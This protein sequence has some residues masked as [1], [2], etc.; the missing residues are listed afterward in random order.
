MLMVRD[1]GVH[2]H[3]TISYLYTSYF[4]SAHVVIMNVALTSELLG[5]VYSGKQR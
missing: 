2:G 1:N 5:K 3:L 4:L